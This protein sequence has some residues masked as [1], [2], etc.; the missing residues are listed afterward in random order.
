[1]ILFATTAAALTLVSALDVSKAVT[2]AT[3]QRFLDEGMNFKTGVPHG[4]MI[5]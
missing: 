3:M 1:M 4:N 2:L 5:R